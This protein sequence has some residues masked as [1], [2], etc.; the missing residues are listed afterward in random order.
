MKRPLTLTLCL[1]HNCNL[2]CRYCYAGR[3]YA[4][5]MD[6]ETAR[7][8]MELGLAEAQRLG[9]SVDLSF[10]GGEPLLEWE[11]L[12]RCHA[13]MQE[14]GDSLC[15]PPRY[16][17]TTNATLL[18]P[19]KL[20]WMAER[21]F[22]VGVSV[23]GSPAMHDINRR[24]ADGTGSHA[25]LQPA[26]QEIR[27]YPALRSKAICVVNPAN[28][29]LLAEGVAW[30]HE[31]YDHEI[32]LNL[33][34]W[35]EWTDEQFD[36]LTAQLQQVQQMMLD[37]YRSGTRP[38]QVDNISGKIYTHLN[39]KGCDACRIGE[40][41]IAVSVDGN[42]FPC[43]RLVGE[44]DTDSFN[45]G[46]VH[47]GID[48]ARQNYI[49]ATRGNAT[50]ACKLC[51]LRTRCMNGCGCSNYAASGQINQVSP[52][53]CSSERLLI[54]LA[55]ELAETLYAEKNPAFMREFYGEESC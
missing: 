6:W 7:A 15:T 9:I 10:F 19:D 38:V 16:G 30:L 22:L 12:Q 43:S 24:F 23:D 55:D 8:G 26:L 45:F 1:T 35:H 37:A 46:N 21:D 17:I 33:D 32:G 4:H 3:K 18:S 13:Y 5:A 48:R 52:F 53:L 40:Q 34:Y 14:R 29:H 27:K 54:R 11:L 49:I 25:A 51:A 28:C 41:E 50:P 36:V 47:S 42:L 44:G 39:G 20:A 31:H 2:R